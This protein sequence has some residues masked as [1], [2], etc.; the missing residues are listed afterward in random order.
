MA[1][2][3]ETAI[4]MAAMSAPSPEASHNS[5]PGGVKEALTAVPRSSAYRL[6]LLP[7]KAQANL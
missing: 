3:S 2:N 1:R 6:A 7:N 4:G 5:F